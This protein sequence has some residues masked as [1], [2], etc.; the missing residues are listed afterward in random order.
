MN[1]AAKCSVQ[2]LCVQDFSVARAQPLMRA[3]VG[4]PTHITMCIEQLLALKHGTR[5]QSEGASPFDF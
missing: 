3:A 1:R 5:G 4:S 2:P